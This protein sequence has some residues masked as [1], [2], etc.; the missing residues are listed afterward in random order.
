MIE[1]QGAT[2]EVVFLQFL[3]PQGQHHHHQDVSF[4]SPSLFLSPSLSLHI[5]FHYL[6]CF[7]LSFFLFYLFVLNRPTDAHQFVLHDCQHR[8]WP[9][10]LPNKPCAILQMFPLGPSLLFIIKLTESCN[11]KTLK[12]VTFTVD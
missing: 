1:L 4:C 3:S 7:L 5:S 9:C 12:I 10:H 8:P 2:G 11:I 6:F